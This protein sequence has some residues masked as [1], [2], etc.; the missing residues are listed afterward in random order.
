MS[1]QDRTATAVKCGITRQ[2]SMFDNGLAVYFPFHI[3]ACVFI[4]PNR[5]ATLTRTFTCQPIHPHITCY[6]NVCAVANLI[7]DANF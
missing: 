7:R 6:V 2:P 3:H 1:E 4:S 5:Q